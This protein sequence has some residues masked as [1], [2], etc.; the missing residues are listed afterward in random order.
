MAGD[1]LAE[2]SRQG[3]GELLGIVE[4]GNDNSAVLVLVI[5]W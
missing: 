4:D 1:R 2:K 3:E 5:H